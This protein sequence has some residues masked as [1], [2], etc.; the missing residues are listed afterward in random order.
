MSPPRDRHLE[1]YRRKRA[2][3]RTPEP[4]GEKAVPQAAQSSPE[5]QPQFVVQKHWARNMH[6]D[7]RLELE[8]TLKSWAVSFAMAFAILA[9]LRS[10]IADGG[11][12]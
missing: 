10:A 1:E 2:P 8:G 9:P 7:L 5:G 6:F 11:R 4:F 12:V 3:G